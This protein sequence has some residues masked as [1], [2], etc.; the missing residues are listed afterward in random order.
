[1]TVNLRH[2]ACPLGA[3]HCYGN[4][5]Q[6]ES[7]L[8]VNGRSKGSS[9]DPGMEEERWWGMKESTISVMPVGATEPGPPGLTLDTSLC[10][11][12]TQLSLW[13]LFLFGDCFLIFWS[14][15]IQCPQNGAVSQYGLG[16]A[17]HL[18]LGSWEMLGL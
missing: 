1:M 9:R 5:K 4:L 6:I 7:R 13:V 12:D 8:V 14:S 3:Q 11:P 2:F 15:V 16:E 10:S 18:D 17:V